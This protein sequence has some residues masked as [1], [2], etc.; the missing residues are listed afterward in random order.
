MKKVLLMAAMLIGSSAAV[1]AQDAKALNEEA[2]ALKGQW[3]KAQNEYYL[4]QDDK[5]KAN[6]FFDLTMKLFDKYHQLDK[7]AEQ[8]DAKGK[9]KNPYRKGNAEI[10]HQNR[11]NLI[12]AGIEGLRNDN[13][14][15]AYKA[16]AAYYNMVEDPM[17]AK[18]NYAQTDSLLSTYAFYAAGS[19]LEAKQYEDVIKFAQYG[20]NGEDGSN[21]MQYTCQALKDLGRNDE[22]LAAL[23]KGMEMFPNANYFSSGVIDYY[24]SNNKV[25]EGL[26]FI[27]SKISSNPGNFYN[28]FLKG[29]MLY[30][31]D[32]YED[33]DVAYKK[34][35]EMNSDNLQLYAFAGQNMYQ[36]AAKLDEDAN[37]DQNKILDYLKRA[38]PYFEMAKKLDTTMENKSWWLMHLNNVYYRLKMDKEY[39]E[40]QSLM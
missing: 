21:C 33:A 35:T 4:A 11:S 5:A 31:Q 39:N 32:K 20:Y 38:L 1:M 12:N 13:I 34:G 15:A 10:I 14:D 2:K 26:T 3:D 36:A 9:V 23:N 27:D 8:P 28:Y 6:A 7:V 19:A 30:S 25:D 29:F 40:L 24:V 37:A 16:F 22:L 18:Y 17:M